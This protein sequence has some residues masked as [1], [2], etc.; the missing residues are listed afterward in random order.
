MLKLTA[1]TKLFI[2]LD[3]PEKL[4]PDYF[5]DLEYT[6]LGTVVNMGEIGSDYSLVTYNPIKDR[7]TVKKKGSYS[8]SAFEFELSSNIPTSKKDMI[9]QMLNMFKES[10]FK[11]VFPDGDILLFTGRV[12]K[13]TSILNDLNQIVSYSISVEIDSFIG[14]ILF[15]KGIFRIY[16]SD[17]FEEGVYKIYHL[18]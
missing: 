12:F 3:L 10:S 4:S 13:K 7:K 2:S 14:E 9:K 11:I 5:L 17:V 1:G 18:L 8:N 6:Q 15:T 16:E